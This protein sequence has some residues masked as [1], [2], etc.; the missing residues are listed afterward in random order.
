VDF[1]PAKGAEHQNHEGSLQFL[2]QA[3]VKPYLEATGPDQGL[4]IHFVHT[5]MGGPHFFQ[6]QMIQLEL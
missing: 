3:G 5:D 2:T 6:L 1:S 4:G